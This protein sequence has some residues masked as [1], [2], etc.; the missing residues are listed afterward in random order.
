MAEIVNLRRVKQQRARAEAD[1]AAAANRVLHGRTRAER[2]LT[3]A[4]KQQARR[5][6]D[7]AALDRDGET[8]E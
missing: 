2:M 8:A 6:L 1:V 3:D 7:G 4:Q 5:V